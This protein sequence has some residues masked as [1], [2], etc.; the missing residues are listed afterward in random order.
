MGSKIK[1]GSHA[2]L[3]KGL[4]CTERTGKS[5]NKGRNQGKEDGDWKEVGQIVQGLTGVMVSPNAH[6]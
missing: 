6:V 3:E 4:G 5:L 2:M 1:Q